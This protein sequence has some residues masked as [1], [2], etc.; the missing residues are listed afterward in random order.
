MITLFARDDDAHINVSC[1]GPNQLL[2]HA[3]IGQKVGTIDKN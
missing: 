1:G 2:D 3:C